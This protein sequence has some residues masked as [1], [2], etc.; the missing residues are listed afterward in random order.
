[1]PPFVAV[2]HQGFRIGPE[3]EVFGPE[4]MSL[5]LGALEIGQL[6]ELH[7]IPP[8]EPNNFPLARRIQILN[9]EPPPPLTF[10]GR[11]TELQPAAGLFIIDHMVFVQTNNATEYLDFPTDV[12]GF[13]NLALNQLVRVQGLPTP[14]DP[15]TDP[16]TGV[17]TNDGGFFPFPAGLGG[18]SPLPGPRRPRALPDPRTHHRVA[19]RLRRGRLVVRRD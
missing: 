8:T 2:N 12:V 7:A 3:T 9:D 19:D 16:N 13:D 4:G 6:V 1:L 17:S 10:E 5:G 15:T 18:A 11:I 14:G